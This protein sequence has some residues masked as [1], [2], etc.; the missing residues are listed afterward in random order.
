MRSERGRQGPPPGG[1]RSPVLR[2][3]LDI[4]CVRPVGCKLGRPEAWTTLIVKRVFGNFF[5][6]F[7]TTFTISL[8]QG[9]GE[10][11]ERQDWARRTGPGARRSRTGG[12]CA[13]GIAGGWHARRESL[14]G[15]LRRRDGVSGPVVHY[16][17]PRGGSRAAHRGDS[18][19][20]AA[21][22][23]YGGA[24]GASLWGSAD[25]GEEGAPVG[26]VALV[27]GVGGG[28]EREPD[29]L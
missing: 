22:G 14:A 18:P 21:R 20:Q 10:Y 27:G 19:R 6:H 17:C 29:G 13:V 7:H 12:G 23:L 3:A 5:V 28:G 16:A 8:P 15:A 4:A 2:V 25:R 9:V 1:C 11:V 24:T 26:W